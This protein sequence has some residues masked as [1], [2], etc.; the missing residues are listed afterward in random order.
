MYSSSTP[1]RTRATRSVCVCTTMPSATGSVQ[2]ASSP[3]RPSTSTRQT[4][5]EPKAFSASV[6]Q[7]FGMSSPAPR[8]ARMIEVPAGTSTRWP[9]IAKATVAPVPLSVALAPFSVATAGVP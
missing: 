9:S 2:D 5:Q 8:A 4:R 1:R 6:A 7:S 3:R